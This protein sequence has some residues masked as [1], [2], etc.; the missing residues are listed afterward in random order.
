MNTAI[1]LVSSITYGFAMLAMEKRRL[2]ATQGADASGIDFLP[3]SNL[4]QSVRED[5]ATI[6]SS[7]LVPGD[8][9]VQGFVY[10]VRTGRLREVS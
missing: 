3:Y 6:R 8:I 9:L 5:V 1:L 7:P 2:R 10:D 4:E